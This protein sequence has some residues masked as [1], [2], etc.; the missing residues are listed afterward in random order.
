MSQQITKRFLIALQNNNIPHY[1]T[2]DYNCDKCESDY[3]VV[4]DLTQKNYPKEIQ[5]KYKICLNCGN[6]EITYEMLKKA[7]EKIKSTESEYGK[8]EYEQDENGIN[9]VE[10]NMP[11]PE[12]LK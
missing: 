3:I 2:D 1:F 12:Q 8:A 5:N 4:A 11:E 6:S 9:I 7:V 10:L